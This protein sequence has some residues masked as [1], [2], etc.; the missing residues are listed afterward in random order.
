MTH[1]KAIKVLKALVRTYEFEN[2]PDDPD[3]I[4]E[5]I[6]ALERELALGIGE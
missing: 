4:K 3:A 5:G 1:Q 6:K 2:N